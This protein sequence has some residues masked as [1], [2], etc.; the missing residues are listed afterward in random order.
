MKH[1]TIKALFLASILAVLLLGGAV[2]SKNATPPRGYEI[3]IDGK[4]FE[5][6]IYIISEKS[7]IFTDN[8]GR[9]SEI[10]LDRIEDIREV[11]WTLKK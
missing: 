11:R 8:Y 6:D 10:S 4:K 5:T 7:L 1:F 9:Q 3:I 2:I